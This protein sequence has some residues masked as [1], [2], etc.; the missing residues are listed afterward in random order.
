MVERKNAVTFKGKPLTLVGKELHPGETA[1]DFEVTDNSLN[2][3][4]FSSY[5]GKNCIISSVV[6][7]DT[8]VCD[9]Q[10]HR[11]NES[12]NKFGKDAAI[13]TISMDLP[14]A[15]KR[16]C[17][18]ANMNQAQTLSDYKNADFGQ[19]FGVLIK[20]LHLL[21]RAVFIIDKEGV[22]RHAH[23]VKEVTEHPNYD[24]IL[25]EFELVTKGAAQISH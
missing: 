15:Q 14:F 9:L 6:S 17:G 2:P 1:P 22:I 7:L 5:L 3:V 8:P 20:E 13:L 19:K 16:W 10:T 4:K 25:K 18:T 12:I 21:G 24:Q 11:F 23:Y